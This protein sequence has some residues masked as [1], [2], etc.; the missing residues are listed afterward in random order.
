MAPK[1]VGNKKIARRRSLKKEVEIPVYVVSRRK[2]EKPAPVVA[3]A[4]PATE[5]NKK[6]FPQIIKDES[7]LPVLEN[8]SPVAAEPAERDSGPEEKMAPVPPKKNV[9]QDIGKSWPQGK[10]KT[11]MWASVAAVT[12]II[13]FVWLAVFGK[14]LS[15]NLG[16]NSYTYFREAVSNPELGNSFQNLQTEWTNLEEYLAGKAAEGADAETLEKL[17]EKILVEE[18][19]NKI[20]NK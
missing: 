1:A 18:M 16:S 12:T 3:Q 9:A 14:N 10:K 2:K 5:E 13:F 4:A 6:V 7:G 20:E 8:I 15:L 11:V 19:K 17:K